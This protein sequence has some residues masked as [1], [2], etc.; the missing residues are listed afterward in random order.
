MQSNDIGEST[1]KK[2]AAISLPA[3]EVRMLAYEARD[4]A[5]S[6]CAHVYGELGMNILS[7]PHGWRQQA[8][9]QRAFLVE[10]DGL[11]GRASDLLNK[12]RSGIGG[13]HPI[14]FKS[15]Y[16]YQCLSRSGRGP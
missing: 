13:K 8:A 16:L 10:Q 7:A 3:I 11:T 14:L 6:E 1:Y 15:C 12:K 5:W 2:I 9:T 4:S